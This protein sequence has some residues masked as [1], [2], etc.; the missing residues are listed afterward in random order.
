MKVTKQ[1]SR[2][3]SLFYRNKAQ[4]PG[5]VLIYVLSLIMISLIF[6]Y[7]YNAVKDFRVR[8]DQVA[9]IK[10][11]T[12]LQS[13]VKA[14]SPDYGS[15]KRE[16][17]ALPEKYSEVCFVDLDAGVYGASNIHEYPIIEDSVNSNVQKNVFVISGA[18]DDSFD[19]GPITVENSFKCF[20]VLKGKLKLELEG[21]G[22]KAQIKSWS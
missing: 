2:P 5:Q 21:L 16:S 17:F 18:V 6:V 22:D 9:Y 1:N 13:V 3:N 20:P 11:K 15:V 4:S 7:G 8:A 12:D 19:L 14:I 10:L